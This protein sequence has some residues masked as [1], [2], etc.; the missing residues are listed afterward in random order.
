MCIL[1]TLLYM[2]EVRNSISTISCFFRIFIKENKNAGKRRAIF[3]IKLAIKLNYMNK[4][5]IR[6]TFYYSSC[7]N[8]Q[9][10]LQITRK[11]VLNLAAKLTKKAEK[12]LSLLIRKKQQQTMYR[13]L[14]LSYTSHKVPFDSHVKSRFQLIWNKGSE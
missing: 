11:L 14:Y 8:R 13:W 7:S 3:C 5:R 10:I 4:E 12:K 1:N 9:N 6:A 2:A